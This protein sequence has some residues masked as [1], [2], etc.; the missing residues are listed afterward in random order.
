MSIARRFLFCV[1]L[2]LT[3]VAATRSGQATVNSGLADVAGRAMVVHDST[4]SGARVACGIIGADGVPSFSRYPGYTG[5]LTVTGS[6]TVASTCG[7]NPA[8]QAARDANQ[9]ICFSRFGVMEFI[10]IPFYVALFVYLSWVFIGYALQF[11]AGEGASMC[12][13]RLGFSCAVACMSEEA[14]CPPE[15]TLGSRQRGGTGGPSRRQPVRA[16]SSGAPVGRP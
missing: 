5:S 4:G 3:R 10:A 9:G 11:E 14:C 1:V 13:P 15:P 16:L 6:M 12:D 8:V 7:L 2:W